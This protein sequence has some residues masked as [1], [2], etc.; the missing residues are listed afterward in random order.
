MPAS[1]Q[2][3]TLRANIRG[4]GRLLRCIYRIA[5]IYNCR[6]VHGN[7]EALLH[8][9]RSIVDALSFPA[10]VGYAMR[11]ARTGSALALLGE[12]LCHWR[13]VVVNTLET[14]A[15]RSPALVR[16]T[17][18]HT[19]ARLALSLLREALRHRNRVVV[20]A[21]ETQAGQS[22]TL[23]CRTLGHTTTRF[24]LS[25]LLRET[26]LHW[27]RC[28]VNTFPSPAFSC[29]ALM[30][31]IA[32]KALWK[33][34]MAWDDRSYMGRK[35]QFVKIYTWITGYAIH[36]LLLGFEARY[37]RR[38]LFRVGGLCSKRAL[39][40]A[41]CDE[42]LGEGDGNWHF[43]ML[44]EDQKRLSRTSLEA[45]AMGKVGWKSRQRPTPNYRSYIAPNHRFI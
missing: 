15:G 40:E 7:W 31:R 44:R 37:R 34:F 29:R 41:Q 5:R 19:P 28:V 11:R 36:G 3:I 4:P 10:L 39:N 8:G 23:V 14:R 27:C 12:A 22:P 20:N 32:W 30:R 25:L 33:M 18:W 16:R 26:L 38:D 42:N 45:H 35:I 43:E 2:I 6:R 21:F 24:T 1:Q 17:L 13:G 9:R